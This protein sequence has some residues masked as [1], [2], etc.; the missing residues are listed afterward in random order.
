[1][2]KKKEVKFKK[3]KVIHLMYMSY[4]FL[5]SVCYYF[6]NLDVIFQNSQ[7]LSLVTQAV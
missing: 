5:Q 3:K 7:R 1:V 2:K 6:Q 4:S